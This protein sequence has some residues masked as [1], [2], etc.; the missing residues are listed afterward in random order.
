[1]EKPPPWPNFPAMDAAPSLQPVPIHHY[2][3]PSNMSEKTRTQ[4]NANSAQAHKMT[5]S[6]YFKATKLEPILESRPFDDIQNDIDHLLATSATHLANIAN[7]ASALSIQAKKIDAYFATLLHHF[8]IN[9]TT[10]P[11]SLHPAPV[12][13][14]AQTATAPLS[15][16]AL[17]ESCST[18]DVPIGFPSSYPS[19]ASIDVSSLQPHS[20]I[21]AISTAFCNHDNQRNPFT[22]PFPRNL[23]SP[24]ERFTSPLVSPLPESSTPPLVSPSPFVQPS[25]PLQHPSLRHLLFYEQEL[26]SIYDYFVNPSTSF[27]ALSQYDRPYSSPL[28]HPSHRHLFLYEARLFALVSSSL[29]QYYYNILACL[30]SLSN[31]VLDLF[32]ILSP[33]QSNTGYR[34]SERSIM[35]PLC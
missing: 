20:I 10:D 28:Q 8:S 32:S 35:L 31:A 33:L 23:L 1:M 4:T 12:P 26:N 6:S 7:N 29:L 18:L 13:S 22:L 34:F 30:L 5:R 11:I 15:T 14:P 19:F 17:P 24:S 21:S 25:L 2:V 3:P 16:S 9:D 27:L